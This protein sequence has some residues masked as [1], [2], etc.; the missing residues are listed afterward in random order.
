MNS[1]IDYTIFSDGGSVQGELGSCACVVDDH[2]R[3]IR[4]KLVA[5][6]GQSTNNEA[7]I[8]AAL[9]GLSLLR[10]RVPDLKGAKV[11]FVA[12]SEYFLKGATDYINNWQKN[13]W[14]T[15]GKAPV[16]NQGLW[17]T[18]LS[19]SAGLKLASEHVRGHTGHPENEACDAACN[20]IRDHADE[21]SA[22]KSVKCVVP[23][24]LDDR[25]WWGIDGSEF[26]I[27]HR[28]E[29]SDETAD[30]HWIECFRR[31]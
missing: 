17:R 26:L 13:G 1:Q 12:D 28:S 6:L 31:S 4:V 7:E 21:L 8:S 30:A 16:K 27:R 14:K 15:S 24:G 29:T 11:K 9:L 5:F 20:W 2:A 10:A 3:N 23:D 18:F 22:T 25:A 19:L